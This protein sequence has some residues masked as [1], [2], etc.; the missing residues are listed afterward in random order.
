MPGRNFPYHVIAGADSKDGYQQWIM[1]IPPD[2]PDQRLVHAG[3]F[4][5]V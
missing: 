3:R 2:D 5:F 4:C 1:C